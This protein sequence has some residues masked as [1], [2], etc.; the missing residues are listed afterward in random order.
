MEP[1]WFVLRDRSVTRLWILV[2]LLVAP[3]TSAAAGRG[4]LVYKHDQVGGGDHWRL[5]TD[6]GAI[7]VWRPSGYDPETSGTVIYVHGYGSSADR[8]WKSSKLVSQFHK[9]GRNAL[10][11][12]PDAP[13]RRGQELTWASTRELLGTV[14]ARTGVKR[15]AGAVVVVAHSSGFRTAAAWTLDPRVREII[16][17]DGFYGSRE[18]FNAWLQRRPD[19][20]LTLVAARSRVLADAWLRAGVPKVRRRKWVPRSDD[21]TAAEVTASVLYLR[22]QFSHEAMVRCGRVLPLLLAQTRLASSLW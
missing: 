20:R 7:H 16:L 11:V 15:P 17:L 22:S 19:N 10:F 2:C 8:S 5:L 18:A 9:S 4:V 6:S 13:R 21:L 1:V 14:A 12:V 3:S